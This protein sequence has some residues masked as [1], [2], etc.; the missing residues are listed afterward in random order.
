M[1]IHCVK[2]SLPA[3]AVAVVTLLT[4]ICRGSLGN[5][6]GSPRGDQTAR[7]D[8]FPAAEIIPD[9]VAFPDT[10]VGKT[11]AQ[12]TLKVKKTPSLLPLYIFSVHLVDT[13]NFD[14]VSDAC[15]GMT[16]SGDESCNIVVEFEPIGTGSFSTDLTVINLGRGIADS[17][18]LEG[19][20]TAPAVTLSSLDLEFGD[21]T[22]NIPSSPQ[23]VTLTNSGTAPLSIF[24]ISVSG[25][26]SATDSCGDTLEPGDS[27][28]LAVCFTPETLGPLSGMVTISDNA[29]GSP[30]LITMGGNGIPPGSPDVSLSATNLNFE[31]Q[32]LNTY[33]PPQTLIMTNVGTVL[34][35]I[36]DISVSGDFE[37]LDSCGSSLSPGQSC[38]IALVFKPVAAGTRRGVVTIQDDATDSP[39]KVQVVGTG[40]VPASASV[41]L[42]TN[43]IDFGGQ[44]VGTASGTRTVLL[45][46]NGRSNLKAG[47][48]A[49]EG[50][51][52][53]NFSEVD[54]CYG[55]TIP[56]NGTCAID[57]TFNPVSSGEKS[58]TLVIT[59]DASDS[60]QTV[61]L[62][63]TGVYSSG[64]DFIL[65]KSSV[66]PGG[67]VTAYWTVSRIYETV[68]A[69]FGAVLPNGITYTL[70]SRNKWRKGTYPI[71]KRFNPHGNASGAISIVVPRNASR[72]T[73]NFGA[74]LSNASGVK[75]PGVV[76]R[77]LV[78][79]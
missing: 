20:G 23:T 40:T 5:E 79:R 46:N 34:L 58:A 3:I 60:P 8:I 51:D 13:V 75:Y 32:S 7:K 54:H 53:L 47:I 71:M 62:K 15:T 49:I 4:L 73:Y 24:D 42:S 63:G 9:H 11:S 67:S 35:N 29:A 26:F 45:T 28:P 2:K 14:I 52:Q 22:V 76:F 61:A 72:G 43:N 33:S 18:S 65:D 74:A 64:I 30:H 78:V 50:G 56:I 57:V 66:S 39:Q 31:S 69:Y 41:K 19:T 70:D 77:P 17:A 25:E 44:A 59:N 48:S 10:E 6:A 55:S 68:D 36:Y 1:K 37:M 38:T 27:C 21:Q 16:L 12:Q